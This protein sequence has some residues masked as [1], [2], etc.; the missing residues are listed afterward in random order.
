MA[1]YPESAAILIKIF[2]FSSASITFDIPIC[3]GRRFLSSKIYHSADFAPFFSPDG[4]FLA[5]RAGFLLRLSFATGNAAPVTERLAALCAQARRRRTFLPAG[6]PFHHCCLAPAGFRV[7]ELQLRF[8]VM[9]T[10]LLTLSSRN[11][12][13]SKPFHY[14]YGGTGYGRRR[15]FRRQPIL[16]CC[17]KKRGLTFKF[18][19]LPAFLHGV[20][21]CK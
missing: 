16:L 20:V 14:A 13:G 8:Y 15:Q 1:K 3:C 6:K 2:S 21:I 7:K 19:L 4:L 12:T 18:F 11:N 9:L 10:P 17:M 5:A